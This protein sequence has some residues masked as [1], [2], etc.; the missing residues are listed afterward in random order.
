MPEGGFVWDVATGTLFLNGKTI[1]S[2]YS[3]APGFVNNPEAEGRRNQGPIPR[4][5]WKIGRPT[6]V[7]PRLGRL[8]IPL[9]PDGHDA[10]GRS[11]FLIHGD[12]LRRPGTASQ[13]CIIL[14]YAVRLFIASSGI[15]G[16]S[17][18]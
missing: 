5:R 14:P 15:R 6:Q 18:E 11:A 17:V 10:K 9:T 3:G 13:G 12:S 16:L 1:G 7:H 2:G 8:V 4:G